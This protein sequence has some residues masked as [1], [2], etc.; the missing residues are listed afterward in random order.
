MTT[1]LIGDNRVIASLFIAL[2]YVNAYA[3]TANWYS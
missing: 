3:I 1:K 2:S